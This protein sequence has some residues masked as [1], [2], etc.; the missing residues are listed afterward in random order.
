MQ[1]REFKITKAEEGAAFAVQ[2]VP[3]ARNNVVVG[4]RGDILRIHLT[5][6]TVGGIANDILINFIAGKLNV[7]R[8]KVEIVAGL[9]SSEKMVI[10]VGIT[11]F[12]A[13]DRLLN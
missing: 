9:T 11:P 5:S 1:D 6:N 4:K 12:E 2:V 7:K 13:E 10:I 8:E 3:K